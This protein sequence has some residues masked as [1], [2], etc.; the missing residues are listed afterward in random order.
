MIK[1]C[2]KGRP[3]PSLPAAVRAGRLGTEVRCFVK[4]LLSLHAF[5]SVKKK[6]KKHGE[7]VHFMSTTVKQTHPQK[8]KEKNEHLLHY[9]QLACVA[10][11]SW[12]GACVA[13]WCP[14]AICHAERLV[15]HEMLEEETGWKHLL[16]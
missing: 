7:C 4:S 2:G 16:G 11:A 13:G 5:H 15:S 9:L 8:K 10:A 12:R 3:P 14:D 6:K 1:G